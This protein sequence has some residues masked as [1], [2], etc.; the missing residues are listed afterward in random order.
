MQINFP[1]GREE[2][3]HYF[4][5]VSLTLPHSLKV[6]RNNVWSLSTSLASLNGLFQLMW[7]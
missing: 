1:Y 4:V 5:C 6:Q 2:P 3:S 7:I